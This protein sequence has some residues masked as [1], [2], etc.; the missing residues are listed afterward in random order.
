[1][2][3]IISKIRFLEFGREAPK[4][5]RFKGVIT[6]ESII[7]YYEY[8]SKKEKA[9]E[10]QKSNT[11]NKGLIGY[12]SRGADLRTYTQM[13]WL[14]QKRTRQF[15][16]L[17][18][19]S[20]RAERNLIWDTVISLKDYEVS[21]DK[22]LYNV[23]DYAAVVSKV[24]PSFFRYAGFDPS[25]MGYWMNY[26]TDKSHPHIHLAFFEKQQTVTKG[27]LS[28]RAV[29]KFKSL[30]I[31]EMAL[32]QEFQKQYGMDSKDF[33]KLI[34]QDRKKLLS[35]VKERDLSS[36]SDIQ[37]LYATL[38]K[39]GRLSYNS[40]HM[41]KYKV[42]IDKIT[43]QLLESSEISEIYSQWLDKVQQLDS[44]ENS[45]ANDN[46]ST[47][48]DAEMKKL[49]SLIGNTILQSFK[50]YRM[51]L[52]TRELTVPKSRMNISEGKTSLSLNDKEVFIAEENYKIY[53]DSA[54]IDLVQDEYLCT[55]SKSGK[56]LILD[57]DEL[58]DMLKSQMTED[59]KSLQPNLRMFFSGYHRKQVRNTFPGKNYLNQ[60]VYQA[61]AQQLHEKEHDI[62]VFLHRNKD[63]KMEV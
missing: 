37:K 31:K 36:F 33:F 13:G 14:D 63:K 54:E 41:A 12:T 27:E 10:S 23:D 5:S 62:E 34:D 58:V 51:E 47:L 48:K 53:E 25:N 43:K 55:D 30:F 9:E 32:R 50:A 8:T 61:I 28:Q 49:Y 3:E 44:L 15:K 4:G 7:G 18:R 2:P 42:D 56:Q 26:H 35:C 1:M 29:N 16:D 6:T 22:Q 52:S 19:N 40:Q 46:I 57:R 59:K 45:Y 38:P 20:F 60:A 24:L 21:A 39:S 17:I 11:F